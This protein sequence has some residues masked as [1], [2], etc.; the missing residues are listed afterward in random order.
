MHKR[1]IGAAAVT[2]VAALLMSACGGS[3]TVAAKP[4]ATKAPAPAATTTGP[5]VRDA[6]ADLVIWADVDRTPIIQK[7]ADEFGKEN[8]IKV[9][10]QVATDVRQQFKDATKVGKSSSRTTRSPR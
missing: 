5:P 9:A 7:Y 1:A 10:V 8:G 4:S 3:T 6:A 2:G